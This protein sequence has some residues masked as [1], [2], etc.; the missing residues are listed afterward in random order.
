MPHYADLE[1]SL[2]RFLMLAAARR[3]KFVF[4]IAGFDFR[5]Q[6]PLVLPV[7]FRQTADL[8]EQLAPRQQ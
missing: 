4:L 2:E 8:M 6:R 7:C 3:Q 1:R 5:R